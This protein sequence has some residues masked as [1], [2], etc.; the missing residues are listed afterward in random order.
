M[1]E[2]QGKAK[3]KSRID[4]LN[5]YDP[6]RKSPD[7][8][9]GLYI[10]NAFNHSGMVQAGGMGQVPLSWQELKAFNECS[11]LELSEFELTAIRRMSSAYCLWMQKGEDQIPSPYQRELTQEER[12]E[13][14]RV[15]LE[16]M[17]RSIDAA[18]K[19]KKRR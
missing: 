19:A 3:R 4:T 5:E 2:Q 15:Q 16:A 11:G 9:A 8:G 6:R 13:L 1:L 18:E 10:V 17:D 14:G 12:Q 7:V